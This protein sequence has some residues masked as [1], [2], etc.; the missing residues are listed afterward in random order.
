MCCTLLLA[1]VVWRWG[2]ELFRPWAGLLALGVLAFDPTLIA[3]GRLATN[4]VGV[5]ALGTWALYRVSR[6]TERPSWRQAL[7][8]GLLLALTAL[9]KGS[10]VL[11]GFDLYRF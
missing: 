10:G 3:H 1:A 7:G 4:D 5:T 8:V 6:W 2:R 9:A 11:W